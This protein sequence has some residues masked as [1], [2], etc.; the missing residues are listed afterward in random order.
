MQARHAVSITLGCLLL[1][2]LAGCEK[3]DDTPEET[4]VSNQLK[5]GFRYDPMEWVAND[6]SLQAVQVRKVIFNSLNPGDQ[7]ILDEHIATILADQQDDGSFRGDQRDDGTYED[8]TLG[9]VEHLLR[10]G[11][12]PEAPELRRA[13][14]VVCRRDMASHNNL[15]ADTIKYACLTGWS[16]GAAP[17]GSAQR[18]VDRCIAG[19]SRGGAGCPWTIGEAEYLYAARD[20]VDVSKALD[21]E[22]AW[23]SERMNAVGS[24]SCKDPWGFVQLAG[25]IDHP[26]GRQIMLRAIPWI[27]RAQHPDGS[28]GD[29]LPRGSTFYVLR[30]LARYD[31]IEPLRRAPPLPADWRIIRAIPA[32]APR[33]NTLAWDG[34]RLWTFCAAE[35][36]AF[37]LSPEDGTILRRLDFTDMPWEGKGASLGWWDDG[38]GVSAWD[39]IYKLDPDT[40]EVLDK[41]LAPEVMNEHNGF[42]QIGRQLWVADSFEWLA[43]VHDLD[44]GT[45]GH[46]ILAQVTGGGGTDMAWDGEGIWHFDQLSHVIV[47]SDL[48]ATP[49]LWTNDDDDPRP[50]LAAVDLLDYGEKP[51]AWCPPGQIG[52]I[53]W[54]GEHLWIIDNGKQRIMMVEKS[55]ATEWAVP[56][57]PGYIR[58]WLVCGPFPSKLLPGEEQLRDGHDTDFFEAA[59]GEATAQ[60]VEG[61]AMEGRAA[62]WRPTTFSRDSIMFVELFDPDGENPEDAQEKVRDNVFYAHTTFD[63]PE[64]C[65]GYLAMGVAGSLKVY[66]NG[67]LV[68]NEHLARYSRRETI[69]IPVTFRKGTNAVLVKVDNDIGSGGFI[70][71]PVTLDPTTLDRVPLPAAVAAD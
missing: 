13:L 40:G 31:L 26:A 25:E 47:K 8:H 19:P 6:T 48:N 56:G 61:Q 3:P 32:P 54:D 43:G 11:C 27:L 53:T 37:A 42:V 28:W 44:K 55:G 9:T 4:A 65:E 29:G 16:D 50:G 34:E 24:C 17:A 33:L 23:I 41:V 49:Q 35:Q 12:S 68:H 21:A 1:T 71:R 70:C 46:V 66:L 57:P 60:P 15:G 14:D 59:G 63:L 64:A 20:V 39:G 38:L 45:W 69:L 62:Q 52:G 67:Q 5:Y 18:L 10:L 2:T 36:T 7:E 30:A 58:D 51:F 22:L